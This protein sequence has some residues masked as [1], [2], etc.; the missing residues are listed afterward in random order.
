MATSTKTKTMKEVMSRDEKIA[1]SN[2][3]TWEL[4]QLAASLGCPVRRKAPALRWMEMN[5]PKELAA[6]TGNGAKK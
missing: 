6:Y 1:A 2:K 5:A 4:I 3:Q